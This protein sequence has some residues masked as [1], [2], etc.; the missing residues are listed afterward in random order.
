MFYILSNVLTYIS[1]WHLGTTVHYNN[2]MLR[3][4][5]SLQLNR[6]VHYEEKGCDHVF[7]IGLR[8]I[9]MDVTTEE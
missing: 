1:L 7:I 2:K 8:P 6:R 4:I 3:I 5:E 9:S